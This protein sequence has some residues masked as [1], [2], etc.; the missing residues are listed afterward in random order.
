MRFLPNLSGER[1]PHNDATIRFTFISLGIDSGISDLT[2]AVI[3]GVSFGLR[4][5]AE[6]LKST[7]TPSDKLFVVG[8]G[9]RS[10]YL[11]KLL[12]IVLDTPL[13][14][15]ASAECGSALGAARLCLS[16]PT[17]KEVSKVVIPPASA[18][19]TEPDPTK[20]YRYHKAYQTS[21]EKYPNIR[22]I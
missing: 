12:T 22:K 6:A 11:S 5:G 4:D 10:K 14:L 17:G 1:T 2:Q 15:P 20:I 19:V 13:F 7:G 16:A 21:W 18:D 3:E 9:S 8:S